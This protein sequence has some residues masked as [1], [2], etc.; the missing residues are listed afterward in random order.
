MRHCNSP[1]PLRTSPM[2]STPL[3]PE[4]HL[5]AILLVVQ[6]RTG[7]RFVFH[8]PPR[9]ALY[10]DTARRQS[11]S[12]TAHGTNNSPSDDSG[13][14]SSDETVWDSDVDNDGRNGLP[15]GNSGGRRYDAINGG[16]SATGRRSKTTRGSTLDEEEEG[17][18]ESSDGDGMQAKRGKESTAVHHEEMADWERLLRYSTDGLQKLLCPP[19]TFHKRRF[20][21]CLDGLLFLGCPMFVREDGLWKK[22]KQRKRQ[23][24]QYE[25]MDAQNIQTSDAAGAKLDGKPSADESDMDGLRR[26]ESSQELPADTST[27][28]RTESAIKISAEAWRASD[29]SKASGTK[30]KSSKESKLTMFHV[31]FVMNPPALEYHVRLDDMYRNVVREFAKVL[32]VEQA[33]SLYVWT[34]SKKILKLKQKAKDESKPGSNRLSK[35]DWILTDL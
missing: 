21:V 19:R 34:Q 23:S 12:Y 17:P 7:P 3:P 20:E 29:L 9:P 24:E 8:Y 33:Q 4:P 5:L 1:L 18:S 35:R 30:S 31:V 26:L 10:Q 15:S 25:G 13:S 32:K 2:Q 6:S 28:P 16:G 22:D 11:S 14:S 27:I